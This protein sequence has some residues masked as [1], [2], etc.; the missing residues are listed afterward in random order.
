MRLIIPSYLVIF[1]FGV[2]VIVRA[3]P[4]NLP[5]TEPTLSATITIT[6][7]NGQETLQNKAIDDEAQAHTLKFI[8]QEI[9]KDFPSWRDYE[10]KYHYHFVNHY[11][12][13]LS[14]IELHVDAEF[15]ENGKTTK[16]M[17]Y[18]GWTGWTEKNGK[19]VGA[20]TPNRQ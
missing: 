8:Q 20:L 14:H 16:K 5:R 7:N 2:F 15:E 6:Y 17:S 19:L 12:K 1:V 18:D 13:K 4:V 10:D 11:G 3:T 9:S